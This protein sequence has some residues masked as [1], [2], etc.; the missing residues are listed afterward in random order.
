LTVPYHAPQT[1]P[2]V[3]LI[4]ASLPASDAGR[5]ES[6]FRFAEAA[7]SRHVR[8]EGTPFIE[9]PVRVA[10]IL[11]EELGNR[12]VDMI[13][14]A[15]NHD[16]LEDCDWL[17]E[18]VL[19]GALGERA[20]GL[21]KAVTKPQ[22]PEDQK[23]ARDRAYMDSLRTISPDARLLKLADRIDNLRSVVHSGDDAKARR[24]LEVS[25]GEFIPLALS[26][27]PVAADLVGAACD[28]IE[29]HLLGSQRHGD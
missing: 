18:S 26:T 27:S 22:V 24:Y 5:V 14:A 1:P 20:T 7:H 21:I 29:E 6:A 25:R 13:V 9:H 2:D 16:V 4:I 19:A 3:A 12:D 11:W 17:D 10:R 23:A 28:A 8:D 15:L